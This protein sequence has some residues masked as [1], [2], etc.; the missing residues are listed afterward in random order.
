MFDQAV[1]YPCAIASNDAEGLEEAINWCCEHMED[2]DT[3][4][5][6]TKLKSN[7]ASHSDLRQLVDRHSHVEHVTNRGGAFI[8]RG[9]PVLMAWPDMSDIGELVRSASR[10][11]SLCVLTWN[12]DEIRPWVA[13]VMPEILGDESDWE[14]TAEDIDPVVIEALKSVMKTVNHNN[15]IAA[16]FEK[17][18]VVS[19]LLALHDAGLQMDGEAMQGWALANGWSGKNPQHLAKYV[20]DIN[21]G[22]RPRCSRVLSGD[23][24]D[25][26]RHRA[27][28][29]NA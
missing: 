18:V 10:I 6:W 5:V 27:G 22:K 25:S 12:E 23:Y 17:D 20:H 16:G 26:L 15:T 2:G 4:T 11:R 29:G 21:A 19:S 13:A 28:E 3:L 7:L 8:E 14:D 24:I 9:G 1:T